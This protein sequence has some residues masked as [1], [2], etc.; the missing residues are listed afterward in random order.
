M[1]ESLK[2]ATESAAEKLK[3]KF[4]ALDPCTIHRLLGSKRKSIYF[5]HNNENVLDFDVV[6]ID[7]SSMIDV[8][9]FAKLLDA[10]GP[11]T[12]LIMLGD[13]DQLASVEAGSMFGDLCQA[14]DKL[15]MF[16]KAKSDLINS[17]I[18]EPAQQISTDYINDKPNNP[19]FE[20]IIEL[21]G[22]HR[23]SD[24]EGIGKFSK[25]ILHNREDGIKEFFGNTDRQVKIDT[26]YSFKLFEEFI[27]GYE[28]FI[29]EEDK[30]KALK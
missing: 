30:S 6:I 24:N 27:A 16:S 26:D 15:N 9:M 21:Q 29:K 5:T 17:Y 11:G 12:R 13:K 23:F 7:E 28:G 22:S 1:K 2:N 18:K 20:H 8:A 14:Q 25:S 10:I 19:L 4:E 3:K